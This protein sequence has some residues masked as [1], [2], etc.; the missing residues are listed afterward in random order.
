MAMNLIVRATDVKN[1]FGRYLQHAVD[2]GEVIIEK[3]G[4]PI[5]KLISL[6]RPSGSDN[7]KEKNFISDRLL[8]ALQPEPLVDYKVARAG[9]LEKK[10]GR[11]D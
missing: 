8:G 1:N 2:N 11:T 5:A 9:A 7:N 4:R 6:A 3:N 10:Y